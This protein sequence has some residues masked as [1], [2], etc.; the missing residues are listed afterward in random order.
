MTDRLTDAELGN[1]LLVISAAL[2]T[3]ATQCGV[4]AAHLK[5]PPVDETAVVV[6]TE[7]PWMAIA[8]REIGQ[9]EIPGA[10]DNP[11]I[12]EYL[13]TT[14]LRDTQIVDETPWCS[15]F[16]N[17]CCKQSGV[18]MSNSAAARSWL[19]V[20]EACQLQ[21]GAIVVLFRGDP[22]GWQGHV[23]FVAGWNHKSVKIL[24]GNQANA[25][26]EKWY[27]RSRVLDYRWPVSR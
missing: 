18:L 20:G 27:P 5:S 10:E 6:P 7:P 14:P 9:K 15:A 12:Q 17:W 22:K 3:V 1:R 2:R 26:S 16:V 21:L 23:G 13:R 11:R 4:L 25:V 8:R 24:G 19:K